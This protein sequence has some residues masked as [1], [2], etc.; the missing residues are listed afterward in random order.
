[1]RWPWQKHQQEQEKTVEGLLRFHTISQGQAA[2]LLGLN[3]WAIFDWMAKR[4]IPVF[5]SNSQLDSGNLTEGKRAHLEGMGYKVARSHAEFETACRDDPWNHPQDFP[6]ATSW[7]VILGPLH[8]AQE[9]IQASDG[10]TYLSFVCPF[11]VGQCY[12]NSHWVYKTE[13]EALEKFR[14]LQVSHPNEEIRVYVQGGT[15]QA[16]ELRG[17]CKC[18]PSFPGGFCNLGDVPMMGGYHWPYRCS[19]CEALKEVKQ[20]ESSAG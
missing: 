7:I 16:S 8:N 9:E 17:T 10:K 5:D 15:R 13:E 11:A 18:F 12:P 1:M 20:G 14:A 3:R 6:E 4:N 2:K 19:R